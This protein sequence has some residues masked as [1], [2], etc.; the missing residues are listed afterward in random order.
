MIA[1]KKASKSATIAQQVSSRIR[2]RGRGAVFTA[3]D[4][5][6]LGT[7]S[8]I[9]WVLQQ[10]TEK[11]SI[12]R[13][14]RGVYDYPIQ[15][16][17]V[18][19]VPPS[20]EAVAKAITKRDGSQIQASG[21]YAANLLGLSEQLPAQ[22][23]F[24]TSSDERSIMIGKQKIILKKTTPRIMKMAGRTSGLIT[25]AFK[26]LGKKS[27]DSEIIE[28]LKTNLTDKEKSQLKQDLAF[29]PAWIADYFRKIIT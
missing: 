17:I 3:S 24:L 23:I 8:T 28:Q 12:R 19:V 9:D 7:R 21:A 27:I 13:L 29:P 25:Q 15:S 22:I 1:D 6:D 16:R 4:F 14:C 26:Y 5:A 11:N 20:P 18:G 10:L 2:N